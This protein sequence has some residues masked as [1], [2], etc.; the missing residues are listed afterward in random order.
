M[1]VDSHLRRGV[2]AKASLLGLALSLL[3]VP[4]MAQDKPTVESLLKQGYDVV[5][6]FPS[7]AGPGILLEDDDGDRLMMCFVAETPQSAEI[8]TQYCKPVR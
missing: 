6:V 5:G 4:A 1:R 2:P 8:V 7:D 3:A